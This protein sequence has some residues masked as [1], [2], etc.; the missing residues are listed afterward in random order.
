MGTRSDSVPNRTSTAIA[1]VDRC[2]VIGAKAGSVAVASSDTPPLDNCCR[3]RRLKYFGLTPRAWQN[4]DAF[5]PL[6]ACS[7]INSRH[8]ACE[9]LTMLISSIEKMATLNVHLASW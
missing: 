5:K 6:A 2:I 4:A 8:C 1:S 7:R 9:R 3:R